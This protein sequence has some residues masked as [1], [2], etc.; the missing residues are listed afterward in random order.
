H[1]I[2]MYFVPGIS[3]LIHSVG[4]PWL[5]IKSAFISPRLGRLRVPGS[6]RPHKGAEKL[7]RRGCWTTLQSSSP[8]R[9]QISN[10]KGSPR[11]GT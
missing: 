9:S 4:Q 1:P 8:R 3:P 2:K 5:L 6:R 11:H 10:N 7:G